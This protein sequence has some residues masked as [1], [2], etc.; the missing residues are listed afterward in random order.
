MHALATLPPILYPSSQSN[1]HLLPARC[2]YLLAM[3]LL[4]LAVLAA[5]PAIV[6]AE[7]CSGLSKGA[8]I[9]IIVESGQFL[10]THHLIP[11]PDTVLV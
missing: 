7:S 3:Q 8:M 6:S 9:A 4:A 1:L 5:A 2:D 10:P 11:F